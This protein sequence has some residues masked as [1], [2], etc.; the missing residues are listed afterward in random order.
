M[1]PLSVNVGD[2][3]PYLVKNMCNTYCDKTLTPLQGFKT[4]MSHF[5]GNI[6]RSV[7]P[8]HLADESII[9]FQRQHAEC[10]RRVSGKI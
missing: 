10:T 9:K 2:V 1:G 4:F 5:V 7:N 6:N 8:L 3:V